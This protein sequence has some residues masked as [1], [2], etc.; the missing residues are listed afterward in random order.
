VL[1]PITGNDRVSLVESFDSA[2]LIAE[3]QRD[4][5]IDI[6]RELTGCDY[7][8]LY[9]CNETGLR[10]FA[11]ASVAGSGGL[12]AQ[13]QKF[14]WYY[15]PWKWEH[16]RLFNRLKPGER[17]LEVGC[18]TGAFIERLCA[19]GFDAKGIEL[20]ASAVAEA[21]KKGL[22]IS[23]HDLWE[24]EV[25]EDGLY[26]VVCSFQVLE[27]L[28]DPSTFIR[29]AL[30]LTKK[31]GR[32]V[33]SAPNH[34]SFLGHQYNLLDMP[35]HHMT[36][37]DKQV[38]DAIQNLFPMD[39]SYVAFEPLAEYHIKAYLEVNR[40]RFANGNRLFRLL[41]NRLTLPVLDGL[42]RMGGRK[43][44]RGQSIYVEFTKQ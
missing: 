26:D 38:F 39:L 19:A 42:L 29:T 20:D 37:W 30:A 11:P 33:C 41:F 16:E 44:C 22:P 31:G 28:V 32:L 6:S 2:K 9:R 35:P 14:D 25:G 4:L 17:A 7:V 27:H 10:F 34:A 18:A 15:M 12:Y 24:I 43:F 36:Q 1:S 8:E 23:K 13:L 40:S 5:G 3:W 21:R